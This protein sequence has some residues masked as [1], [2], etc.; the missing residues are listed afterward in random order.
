M[1]NDIFGALGQAAITGQGWYQTN[2]QALQNA[3][4]QN[5]ASNQLANNQLILQQQFAAAQQAA[6]QRPKWMIDGQTFATAEEFAQH[7]WPDD[8][9]ARLMFKLKYPT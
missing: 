1:L 3:Y 9:Q 5:L 4:G 6:F 8:E 2:P 7:I